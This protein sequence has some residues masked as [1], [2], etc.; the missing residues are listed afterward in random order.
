[1]PPALTADERGRLAG[2]DG[3]GAAIAMRLVLE[4]ASLLGAP[5]LVP[6]ASAHVD[7]V[8]YHG[9]SGTRFA[10][11]L[12]AAGARVAVPTTLNVGAI[13]LLNPASVRLPQA[14]R[15]SALRLMR[16]HEALGCRATFTCAPYEA[17]HRPAAGTD[18]AWGE[19]NA[20]AFCNAVLGARTNRYGDFLDIACA[21]AGRAPFTGLHDPARRHA[22]LLFDAS[23]LPQT[24]KADEALWPVLGALAGREAGDAV[25]A[26]DGLAPFADEARLKAFGAAAA[27]FGAV[28]LFHVVGAT[29]EAPTRAAAFGGGG[30]QE[31]RTLSAADIEDAFARM[32]TAPGDAPVT[33]V[34]VGSPHLSLDE[35][36]GLAD[37]LAGRR[38]RI[39]L[40]AHTGRHVLAA[41]GAGD[42][43][44][45]LKESGVTLVTDTCIVT[46]PILP[47]D[48]VLMTN[49]GKFATYAPGNTGHAAVFARLAD[50]VE[51]AVTGARVATP[52]R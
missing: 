2:A 15:R 45:R 48:G 21:I 27:A 36:R 22:R 12:V 18:V 30:P 14:E 34:A 50:C 8:L 39:P 41:P 5:R 52:W 37:R 3:E 25:L 19:S 35:C 44:R 23:A 11:R 46:T 13:D 49:S 31:T 32:S 4:A 7:G 40:Y 20:V 1:V 9:D 10:E 28:A 6:V 17:G 24:L 47:P 26:I 29:P 51:T 16:A 43:V 33:A 42:T 38:V